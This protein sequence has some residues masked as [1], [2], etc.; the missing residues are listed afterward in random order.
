MPSDPAFYA[1]HLNRLR[2]KTLPMELRH[3]LRLHDLP[4]HH[5]DPFDRILISQALVEN[6]V[7]ATRDRHANDYSVR[8]VWA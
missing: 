1:E 5:K 2:A 4:L 6:L 3:A 7:F 8:T